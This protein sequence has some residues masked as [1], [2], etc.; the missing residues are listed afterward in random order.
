MDKWRKVGKGKPELVGEAGIS[1]RWVGKG[2]E[3]GPLTQGLSGSQRAIK[4]W[5][6]QAGKAT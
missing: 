5:W 4:A 2:V 1:N 6:S 3:L